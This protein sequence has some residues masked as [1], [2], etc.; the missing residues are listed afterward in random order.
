MVAKRYVDLNFRQT[1][2]DAFTAYKRRRVF[3]HY[4]GVSDPV[5]PEAFTI[6]ETLVANIAGGDTNF[7]FIRTNEEQIDD[8][9]VLNAM[10]DFHLATNQIGLKK[11]EW[12]REMLL[13]GTGILHVTWR[14]GKPYI[15]NIPLRDFYV[16]ANA[17]AMT[18][19]GR[20]IARYSGYQYLT[21][22][23]AL[24]AAEVYDAQK[25]AMV[26]KYKNL[27]Y[28]GLVPAGDQD[29]LGKFMDKVFKDMFQ[30]ST[31]GADAMADQVMVILMYDLD[32]GRLV[33]IG[34]G[35]QFIYYDEIPYHRDEQTK[36]E[37]IMVPDPND[38][39]GDTMITKTVTR[40]LDEIEAFMPFA[41][42]RDYVDTSLFYGEGE[43]AV[44]MDRIEMLNDLEAMDTDNIAYQN[45][46]M[47]TIDPQFADLA[48]DIETTPGAVYPIPKGAISPM[49]RPQ[50]GQDLDIKKD[51]VI[52]QMRSAS[53]A[54][55]AVQGVGQGGSRTTATE[56][57]TQM[58]QAQNR[59]AT[60]I[61]NLQDEGFAQLGQILFK[62][63]QIFV[64]EKQAI[65][66]VGPNG[67]YFKDYDPWDY[68]GEYQA[69]VELDSTIQRHDM[70]QGQKQEQLF[71]QLQEDP[72]G[73]F[74]PKEVKR[75]I[76]Q[77]IDPKM[78]DEKFNKMLSNADTK[79]PTPAEIKSASDQRNAELLAIST[80]Y[81]Y[82]T[83]FIQ[84]QIETI[85]QMHPDPQHEIDEQHNAI[86]TGAEQADLLNPHTDSE[87]NPDTSTGPMPGT[88]LPT[89]SAPGVPSATPTSG[90]PA[91]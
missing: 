73:I 59:F 28:L 50:L 31:L 3:R 56:V 72:N 80:I 21:S 16:D 61:N 7:H 52:A 8:T 91:Q 64:T 63:Y 30:G 46:P 54:D 49:E 25:N 19:S 83:P 5:I 82:A 42:L 4:E 37:Q 14:D 79:G 38:P 77:H 22:K 58:N 90:T 88:P 53:A 41:V 35:K 13:Y 24:K 67:I 78:T 34:N 9:E 75:F 29:G 81:R 48:P 12:V 27:D 2:D 39:T 84:A 68:N 36:Q 74:D 70:E 20:P 40:K 1:W 76:V 51:R 18:S 45:T 71:Q 33:E 15:E 6:I 66:I 65:R 60:K 69:N 32:S 10:T 62:M 26:P 47:Y 87:G 86:K 44:L 23:T 11:Q 89:P 17:S 57:T 85:L 43:M 55:E